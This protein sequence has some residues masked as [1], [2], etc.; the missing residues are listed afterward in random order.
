MP[1]ETS[2]HS[3]R[4][5]TSRGESVYTLSSL[6]DF[7]SRPE[8]VT[9]LPLAVM[10]FP[11]L[12]DCHSDFLREDTRYEYPRLDG[13][14][15]LSPA[16]LGLLL[17][18]RSALFVSASEEKCFALLC[19]SY[20]CCVESRKRGNWETSTARQALSPTALKALGCLGVPGRSR[21]LRKPG[22]GQ[23]GRADS[24]ESSMLGEQRMEEQRGYAEEVAE[25][26]HAECALESRSSN[27]RRRRGERTRD[28]SDCCPWQLRQC[29]ASPGRYADV[30]REGEKQQKTPRQLASGRPTVY[31]SECLQA[32]TI[33]LQ[34]RKKKYEKTGDLLV[35]V[36]QAGLIGAVILGVGALMFVS[37]KKS[38]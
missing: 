7:E 4:D 23:Q 30:R 12:L 19:R 38:G 20:L 3:F 11:L 24:E 26:K 28:V 8:C 1:H 6:E 9:S 21:A 14:P 13:V 10:S 2:R 31:A 32:S 5:V 15:P 33:A 25:R 16:S 35:H 27:G 18:K 22:P 36:T 29:L 34:E 17:V 37:V